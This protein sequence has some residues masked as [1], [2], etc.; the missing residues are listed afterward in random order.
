M[1]PTVGVVFGDDGF[2]VIDVIG[3]N[4]KVGV[5]GEVADDFL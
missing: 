2:H 5:V 3:I 4:N 1:S